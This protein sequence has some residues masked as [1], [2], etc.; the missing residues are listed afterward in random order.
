MN[1]SDNILNYSKLKTAEEKIIYINEMIFNTQD[2]INKYKQYE[3]ISSAELDSTIS[4]LDFLGDLINNKAN[5]S[6][7][8]SYIEKILEDIK[9]IFK[10][11]GTKNL[12]DFIYFSLGKEVYNYILNTSDKNLLKL[13]LKFYHP[14]S[15]KTIKRENKKEKN[16]S[17]IKPNRIVED[18]QLANTCNQLDCIDLSRSESKFQVRVHG[19]KIFI[20]HPDEKKTSIISGIVDEPILNCL[21]NDFIN[22]KKNILKQSN[23]KT[24]PSFNSYLS[25]L[26]LKSYLCY[27]PETILNRFSTIKNSLDYMN[28]K[29]LAIIVQEFLADSL[30]L[31]RSTLLKLLLSTGA[32][33]KYLAYLLYDLLSVEAYSN[34]SSEQSLIYNSLPVNAR[35]SFKEAMKETIKYTNEL[36][37]FS[38]NKIP[39]EQQICLLKA[40]DTIKEKAMSKLKEIRSKSDDSG[41]KARQYL[42]GLLK[43]PFGIFAEEEI[44]SLQKMMVPDLKTY[45]QD[46]Y[47][48]LEINEPLADNLSNYNLF[49]TARKLQESFNCI[50]NSNFE[51]L[52]RYIIALTKKELIIFVR[53]FN[54]INSNNKNYKKIVYAQ[55]RNKDVQDS[56][57]NFLKVNLNNKE[58]IDKYYLLLDD[59]KRHVLY[60]NIQYAWNAI[61]KKQEMVSSYIKDVKG[62]LNNSVFGH[63]QPKRQIER[64]IGQWLNGENQG[65][66]FGFEGPPGVGKTSL[67]KHGIAKCLKDNNGKTRPF[68]FIA[69]GGSS[70]GSLFEGHNYTYVGSTWGKIC[71]VLMT[72]KC[73]NP[74]IFIDE[75]DKISRTEHG[76]EIIGI[77]THLIDDTQNE[78]FQDR[79]F[80]GIDLDLS[81]ALFIFSYND[82]DQIDKIL[83]DRIH[84]VKFN[85]LSI[86]EKIKITN[87]FLIPD[88]LKKIGLPDLIYMK[89]NTIKDIIGS[90]THEAGVRKLKQILFEIFSEVNLE[91]LENKNEFN[92]PLELT[93]NIIENK[94]LKNRK[95]IHRIY[96]SK[97]PRIGLING[98]WANALGRGG[99]LPIEAKWFPTSNFL[100]LKLTGKQGD[101]MK[102]SMNV[103]KTL[104]W[105]HTSQT[106]IK[107]LKTQFSST[108]LQ[109]IHIH[110]PDGATPK[111]GPSAGTAIA[112]VIY[113][114]LNNKKIKNDVA[115]TGEINLNGNITIIGGLDC[116]INGAI[117]AGVKTILYPE[118]NELD[119]IEFMDRPGTKPEQFKD[120]QFIKVNSF[121]QAL[122]III[123]N[124]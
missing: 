22:E 62:I 98:L 89:D 26:T 13:L 51:K 54:K 56:I 116:K 7:L 110:C 65:Y 52:R 71:D 69:V 95:K 122:D 28:N 48:L 121:K 32:D 43:I 91:I 105:N 40:N 41:S 80:T 88:I 46:S 9:N 82:V 99:V 75:L 44:L 33:S 101:V 81:K 124:D 100:D 23:Y 66:A 1:S 17:K 64:I 68:S 36:S 70:N 37:T 86:D 45:I 78:N 94:Y 120:I 10:L 115:L 79:Y 35:K 50:T 6:N 109:G 83:L 73:M 72:S 25:F 5:S 84:R 2:Y 27:K 103:A 47:Q 87:D 117:E 30:Y 8:D 123:L 76:K 31:Q 12:S 85:S 11:N 104:A 60:S 119:F 107:K 92:F 49:N 77:L 29:E 34:D 102:E 38:V 63:D 113:S 59:N 90:Y 108:K 21:N 24:D 58:I 111:D 112:I 55:K 57:I 106:V 67:A 42:E 19:I 20:I 61:L 3:L 18:L 74:I 14:Y 96:I 16:E 97:E 114:L 118:E 39:L 53:K 4:K 93:L 15:F